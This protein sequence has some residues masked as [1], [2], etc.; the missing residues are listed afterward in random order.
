MLERDLGT[1]RPPGIASP[2]PAPAEVLH[3]VSEYVYEASLK[4]NV[5]WPVLL[6]LHENLSCSVVVCQ[7]SI[8]EGGK[9]I[10][11][12][13]FGLLDIQHSALYVVARLVIF[14]LL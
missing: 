2:L 5:R 1:L 14:R 8:Q 12:V 3:V 11:A 6:A 9:V 10:D 7:F 4:K 13:N